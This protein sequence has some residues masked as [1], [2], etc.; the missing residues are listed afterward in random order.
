MWGRYSANDYDYPIDITDYSKE[1]SNIFENELKISKA[2]QVEIEKH[3]PENYLRQ[4][5]R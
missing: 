4:L 2:W 3:L 5:Q 1:H